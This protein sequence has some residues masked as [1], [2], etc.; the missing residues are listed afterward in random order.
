MAKLY[1]RFGF[2]I[3]GKRNKKGNWSPLSR[4]LI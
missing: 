2:E 1:C 3:V 4:L